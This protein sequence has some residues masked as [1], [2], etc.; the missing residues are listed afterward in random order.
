MPERP[1]TRQTYDYRRDYD[2]KRKTSTQEGLGWDWTQA[3]DRYR[4]QHPLCVAC[5][6][7]G[8][9]VRADCV[10]HVIPRATRPDLTWDES[11]WQSLCSACHGHK[12]RHE[13]QGMVIDWVRRDGWYVLSG[14]P[15]SGKT[16]TAGLNATEGDCVW[17]MD[18]AAREMGFTDYPRPRWQWERLCERRKVVL[19]ALE[20]WD[21]RAW[22]IVSSTR[23]AYEVAKRYRARLL[24]CWCDED[25]RL[26]RLA[27]RAP[28]AGGGA[29]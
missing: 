10:D 4:T 20:H 27:M 22:I 7:R 11:N 3:A 29:G 21:G 24:H 19:D 8:I 14:K 17:D 25:E 18:D 15:G 5:H 6:L 23:H 28:R 2:R 13:T 12:T 16:F 1:G 26:A 9:V